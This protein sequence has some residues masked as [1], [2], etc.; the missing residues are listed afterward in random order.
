M[1]WNEIPK[2]IATEHCYHVNTGIKGY[3][4]WIS[5]EER[6]MNLQMNPDFQRGHVWNEE[7]QSL[8]IEYLLKGG[9]SGRAFYFN[10][11]TYRDYDNKYK[12]YVCV[13]GL[14]RSTAI[15]RF[16]NGKLK[17]FDQYYS[18]FGSGL[19]RTEFQIDIYINDLKTKND[20]LTWYVQMNEGGTPHTKEEIERVKEMILN[21]K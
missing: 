16:I 15:Q 10:L 21:L 12:D 3:V 6:E 13:D 9:Q 7:Q 8:Y 2:F 18:D 14:Q 11:P 1:K 5:D 17:A 20:V 19:V 4:G